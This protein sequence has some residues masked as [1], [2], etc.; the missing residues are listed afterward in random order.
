MG[1]TTPLKG[2]QVKK[3]KFKDSSSDSR[4]LDF[5]ALEEEYS[6]ENKSQEIAVH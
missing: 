6:S 2:S 1:F 3:K 5:Q 4:I